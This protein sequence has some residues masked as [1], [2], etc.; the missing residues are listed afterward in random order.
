AYWAAHLRRPVLLD[1]SLRLL[2]ESG[3]DTFLELGPGASML[4]A[5]RRS[6][7]WDRGHTTVPMLGRAGDEERGLL[8]ALGTLWE[9]GAH[10]ALDPAEGAALRCSLPG[11]PFSG[12]DPAQAAD[13]DRAADTA[14]SPVP[15]SPAAPGR[16][17]GPPATP[18]RPDAGGDL[19][20]VLERAW[21]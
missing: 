9:R 3:C 13:P 8:Q 18:R 15:A 5:L 7:G 12:R 19:R 20:Q 1:A 2:L 17:P 11:H 16:S 21:C 4:A 14:R 6:E 10:P